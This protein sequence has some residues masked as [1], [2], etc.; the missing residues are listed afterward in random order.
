MRA[1]MDA[2]ILPSLWE[3]FGLVL[4]EAQAAGLP[5]VVSNAVSVETSI[6]HKQMIRLPLS[7]GKNEW[8]TKTIDSLTIR[9][10]TYQLAT[11]TLKQTDFCIQRS[12]AALA[13]LYATELKLSSDEVGIMSSRALADRG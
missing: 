9:P 2:F 8:A 4:I 5:C 1:C 6:F 3:G 7:D 11:Q 13:K 12:T 10:V